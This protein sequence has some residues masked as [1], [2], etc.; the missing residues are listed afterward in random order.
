MVN[1]KVCILFRLISIIDWLFY[2]H[3]NLHGIWVYVWLKDKNAN[4][5]KI[6]NT[7]LRCDYMKSK[8]PHYVIDCNPYIGHNNGLSQSSIFLICGLNIRLE[9]HFLKS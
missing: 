7:F 2:V 1:K 8:E 5:S 9:N 3:I 4:N 6:Y